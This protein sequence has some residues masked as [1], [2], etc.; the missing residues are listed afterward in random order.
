[1]RPKNPG[2]VPLIYLRMPEELAQRE[3]ARDGGELA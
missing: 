1:M 3:I 2:P